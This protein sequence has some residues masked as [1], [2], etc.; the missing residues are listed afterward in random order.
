MV[1]ACVIASSGPVDAQKARKTVHAQFAMDNVQSVPLELLIRHLF[2]RNHGVSPT[3]SGRFD[4][5]ARIGPLCLQLFKS[6]AVL[7][8][9]RSRACS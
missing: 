2:Q 1:V 5:T 6:A 4:A 3:G 9:L 7:C 8:D